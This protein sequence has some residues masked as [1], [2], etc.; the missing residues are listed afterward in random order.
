[1]IRLRT[2]RKF[3]PGGGKPKKKKIVGPGSSKPNAPLTFIFIIIWPMMTTIIVIKRTQSRKFGPSFTHLTRPFLSWQS[4]GSEFRPELTPTCD[5]M[6]RKR[7]VVIFFSGL[8]NGPAIHCD[9]NKVDVEWRC[10]VKMKRRNW[11]CPSNN[12]VINIDDV[13]PL[14]EWFFIWRVVADDDCYFRLGFRQAK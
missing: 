9:N 6:N 10:C 3:I 14:P 12:Y 13:G 2:S 11:I 5:G 1:M 8:F 4:D 7:P